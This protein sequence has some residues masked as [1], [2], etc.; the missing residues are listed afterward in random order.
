LEV[1]GLRFEVRH[2]PGHAPGNVLFYNAEANAAFVGDA[3]FAGSVGRPDLP[4]GDWPQLENSIRTQ[5]YTL[6]EG[7]V[8]YP[9]HGPVTTVARERATN[10][11]VRG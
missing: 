2:V 10:R 8:L 1:A 11:F 6:P 5:I 7:T 4:G 9:G 3:I